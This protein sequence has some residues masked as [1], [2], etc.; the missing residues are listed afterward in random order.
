MEVIIAPSAGEAS[1]EAARIAAAL[2]RARPRAVLGLATGSTPLGFYGELA[3]MHS[4]GQLDFSGVTTFNL[5]E[6]VGLAPDHPQ[7]YARFMREH[8]FS[9]V[10]IAPE[11]IH[12]PDGSGA[13]YP[14]PL[15]GVRGGDPGGRAASTCN[16]LASV[17]TGT[18]GS[19]SRV[20]RLARGPGSRRSPNGP[21]GITRGF[22]RRRRRFRAM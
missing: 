12:I 4:R 3:A 9:K 1:A 6:Y 10:N 13:G 16:C 21:S 22:L 15:R 2:I 7:S 5:D 20:P 8:F 18:S 19:M 11:R 17:R 14:G